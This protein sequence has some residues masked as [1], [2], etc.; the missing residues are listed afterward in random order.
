MP[1]VNSSPLASVPAAV[2]KRAGA[3]ARTISDSASRNSARSPDP[4]RLEPL[5]VVAIRTEP[6]ATAVSGPLRSD[7]PR[8][9]LSSSEYTRNP[10]RRKST[11]WLKIALPVASLYTIDSE[12]TVTKVCP[13][14]AWLEASSQATSTLQSALSVSVVRS[15]VIDS[16]SIRFLPCHIRA[17]PTYS[18]RPFCGSDTM[19]SAMA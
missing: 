18:M 3:P 6:T 15:I 13:F 17:F 2:T 19:L 8:L 12:R 4:R 7:L 5:S 9:V 11:A 16:A 14:P 10:S 1:K